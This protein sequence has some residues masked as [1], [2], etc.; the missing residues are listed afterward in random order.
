MLGQGDPEAYEEF[1][2]GRGQAELVNHVLDK[3]VEIDGEGLKAFPNFDKHLFAA[4][5]IWQGN[6]A[7]NASLQ[8]R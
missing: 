7:G 2:S 3:P 1:P 8:T 5:K 6:H 4:L